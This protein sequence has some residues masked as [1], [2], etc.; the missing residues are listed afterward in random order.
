MEDV[1]EMVNALLRLNME[2][3]QLMPQKRKNWRKAIESVDLT[4][5][6]TG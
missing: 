1:K 2:G 3:N 5:E 4:P 6:K